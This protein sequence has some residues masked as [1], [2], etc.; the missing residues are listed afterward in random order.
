MD[1]IKINDSI[2]YVDLDDQEQFERII[3]E[4]L[5]S[6][7]LKWFDNI[8]LQY[9]QSADAEE[10]ERIADGYYQGL[11]EIRETLDDDSLSSVKKVHRV[12]QT[13]LNYI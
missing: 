3:R 4:K 7:M 12:K 10:Y 11:L 8:L 1:S 9:E 2:I 6:D 13:L 5:G